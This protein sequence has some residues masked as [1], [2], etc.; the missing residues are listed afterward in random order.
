MGYWVEDKYHYTKGELK[1]TALHYKDYTLLKTPSP[2]VDSNKDK[3]RR[4]LISRKIDFDRSLN[5]IGKG[6][7]SGTNF[8]DEGC[9]FK[10]FGKLQQVV[11]ADILG[12]ND[13]EL[14]R[15]GFYDIHRIRGFAYSCMA[16]FLNK[17]FF[18]VGGNK[19]VP[20]N[21]KGMV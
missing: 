19:F 2:E 11:I 5:A 1:N 3:L 6:K 20:S 7:W 12:I 18:N 21:K 14:E 4:D 13:W 10:S 16:D 9:D 15:M 8:L 17:G